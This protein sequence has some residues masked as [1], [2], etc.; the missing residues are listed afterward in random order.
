[1]TASFLSNYFHDQYS[2][3]SVLQPQA[4]TTA[5]AET[6]Y[7]GSIKDQYYFGG[8]ALLETGFGVDQYSVALTPQGNGSYILMTQGAAGNYYLRANTLARRVQGLANLYLPPQQWHGRHDLKVGVDL[9]RLN[10]SAALLRQ[11]ISFLLPNE[12]P[13]GQLPQPCATDSNG[14]PVAPYTCARYSVFSGGDYSATYNV[15]ASA[16]AEDRWLLTNRLLIEPGLRFDWDEIVR[17]PLLSPRLA[18]TYIFDEEGNTKLS[19]GIG[20]IHDNTPLGL[21]QQPLEGQRADYFWMLP[22]FLEQLHSGADR[23]ERQPDQSAHAGAH[24]IH[25]EAEHPLRAALFELEYRP[26]EKTSIRGLSQT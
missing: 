24:H 11:P 5:D 15:E 12:P 21:I 1:M 2:G 16:Y 26:G 9:D 10:H 7:I 25:R 6:A 4:T 23:C 20:V 13:S 8:G 18:G 14:V 19:A 22:G 3:L 17:T